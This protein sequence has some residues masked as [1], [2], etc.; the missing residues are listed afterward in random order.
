[1]VAAPEPR[2]RDGGA[3]VAPV[4]TRASQAQRGD[5]GEP[6]RQGRCRLG[7]PD[8]LLCP[9]ALP[10][11]EGPQDRGGDIRHPGRAR[12]RS[13][14]VH[15]GCP[16]AAGYREV[17]RRGPGRSL[18]FTAGRIRPPPGTSGQAARAAASGVAPDRGSPSP[19]P[20]PG[21]WLPGSSVV[22]PNRGGRLTA[23]SGTT[24]QGGL[25]LPG[26]EARS[27]LAGDALR[28]CRRAPAWPAGRL[29]RRRLARRG[30][31]AR[32]AEELARRS[33]AGV[34]LVADGVVL[35]LHR[36][37]EVSAALDGDGLVDDVALDARGGAEPHLQPAQPSDDAAVDHDFL[38]DHLAADGRSLADGEMRCPDVALDRALDLDIARRGDVAGDR[39]VG[40][41]DGRSSLA[42]RRHRHRR[43]G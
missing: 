24:W 10:D 42:A 39:E 33:Q 22:M 7:Q 1:E 25:P 28:W 37:F 14:P 12:R 4:R 21:S 16:R 19:F 32:L 18:T 17:P 20:R 2:Q 29:L 34:R 5:P 6:R 15:G 31:V 43:F 13:R 30:L 8:P 9:P 23:G 36:T 11:G 41:K 26:V 3:E 40:G 38:R 35:A 27:L